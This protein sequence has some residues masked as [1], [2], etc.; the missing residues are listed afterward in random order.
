MILAR[1]CG[2]QRGQ[3]PIRR[4]ALEAALG[5]LDGAMPSS[6]SSW[7]DW[8]ICADGDVGAAVETDRRALTPAA[9]EVK[10]LAPL[11]PTMHAVEVLQ[12]CSWSACMKQDQVEGLPA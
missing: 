4:L 10:R 5:G 9:D 8:S 6:C 11:D 7:M 12:F 1:G 3:K 2:N